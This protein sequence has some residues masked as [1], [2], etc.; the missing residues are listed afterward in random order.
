MV[1]DDDAIGMGL[2]YSLE[3]EGYS[4]LDEVVVSKKILNNGRSVT[5]V[6][7]ETASAGFVKELAGVLI[8][9]YGQNEHQSLLKKENQLLKSKLVKPLIP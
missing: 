5:R 6:N 1:E 7:G 3:K 4:A 8:D 9:I 2:K